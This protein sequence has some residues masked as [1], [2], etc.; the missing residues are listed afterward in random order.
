MIQSQSRLPNSLAS[1]ID[2]LVMPQID[3]AYRGGRLVVVGYWPRLGQIQPPEC[4]SVR[5]RSS[6]VSRRGPPEFSF[7]DAERALAVSDAGVSAAEALVSSGAAV[8]YSPVDRVAGGR[9]EPLRTVLHSSS[10]HTRGNDRGADG[11]VERACIAPPPVESARDLHALVAL[12]TAGVG[13]KGDA[14]SGEAGSDKC[15]DP[16]GATSFK[17]C[18]VSCEPSSTRAS[19]LS[20]DSAIN[21][22]GRGEPREGLPG[23]RGSGSAV[24][25]VDSGEPLESREGSGE[26]LRTLA[27]ALTGETDVSILG[28]NGE[29]PP[30]D[31]SG[32]PLGMLTGGL[33]GDPVGTLGAKG[34]RPRRILGEPSI[35]TASSLPQRNDF[36]F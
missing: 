23:G 20:G 32:E 27:F 19:S 5:L 17:S 35:T 16:R 30:F 28:A 31:G 21:R 9:G 26:P 18:A 6:K 13:P 33:T 24:F 15:G 1:M 8:R 12:L 22:T 29:R 2:S 3:D 4:R 25:R 34:E 7:D 14:H 10:G 36:D 11:P